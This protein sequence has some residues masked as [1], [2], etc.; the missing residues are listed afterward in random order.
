MRPC[1]R[2]LSHFQEFGCPE[3]GWDGKSGCPMWI[4]KVLAKIDGDG[5]ENVKGCIDVEWA[6]KFQY[7]MCVL[8][9]GNQTATEGLRNGL[10]E[11]DAAGET[12]PKADPAMLMVLAIM[13]R[14]REEQA[15]QI[16]QGT[17]G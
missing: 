15:R 4:E 12:I 11:T 6:F 13:K 9:E 2:D 10:C 17:G 5:H 8:L 7:S 1:I 3:K 14:D 16:A